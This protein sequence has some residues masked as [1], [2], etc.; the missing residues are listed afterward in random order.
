MGTYYTL[1]P[2]EQITVCEVVGKTITNTTQ[3]DNCAEPKHPD[4][5]V[6]INSFIISL[7]AAPGNLWTILCMDKLGRKFFLCFS[8]LLSGGSV[9]LI[10]IVNS[11][12]LNLV[13][14][15]ILEQCQLLVSTVWTALALNYFQQV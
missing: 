13:L 15:S 14:S 12:T 2:G 8:M 11:S 6:F 4:S 7:S 3:T 10:Y 1:H 5:Q 9:F